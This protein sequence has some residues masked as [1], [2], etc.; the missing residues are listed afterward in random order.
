MEK[1]REKMQK[2][3]EIKGY[4]RKTQKTYLREVEK[5][6][7]HF[8]KSPEDL[9]TNEIKDYLHYIITKKKSSS[10]TV[11]QAYS[12]LK[13][14]YDTVMEKNW[15]FK[16]I[17]RMKR[18]TKLPVVLSVDEV[19]SILNATHNL[20]HRAILSVIYSAGLRVSEAAKLKI[21][22]IDSTRMQIR[23]EQAKGARD[24]YTLLSEVALTILRKYWTV[25]HPSYWLFNGRDGN[26]HL[27][28]RTIQKV[29]ENCRNKAGIIK[30][31]TVHTLRHS[32]ATHLLENGIGIH[33]IQLLLGHSSP[34][35]TTVYLHVTRKDLAKIV[36]PL[37]SIMNR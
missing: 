29:F 15:E 13:F 24:R 14:L 33:H 21:T 17:P 23:V 16:H 34:K 27:S 32:F 19:T 5:F 37:D 22:D 8:N 10:S 11:H 18:K 4:S 30:P 31:V 6:T 28:E 35:T 20:K 2:N 9:G 36:S 26:T 25:Y 1:L 7:K 3:L 12:A